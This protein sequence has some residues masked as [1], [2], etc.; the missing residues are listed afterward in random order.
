MNLERE[1]KSF[2]R[3]I[4]PGLI[5]ATSNANVNLAQVL[6]EVKA[7]PHTRE[8]LKESLAE[9]LVTRDYTTAL[10][11]T[12][13]TLESGMFSEI[14]KRLEYKI[15]PKAVE[16]LDILSFLRRIFD[17]HSDESWLEEIDRER[18]GE[19]L[20]LILPSHERLVEKLAPQ[21]FMSLEILS[22]RLAGLGYEP[23]VTHR[24]RPRREFQHAFMDVARHV[25][26]LLEK[27]ES[28]IPDLRE[29]LS[30]CHQAVLWIR[31]RRGAEG[32]SLALTY[33]MI[34]I[35]E[36]IRRLELLVQLIESILGEWKVEPAR[37]LFFEV[38]LAEIRR[39]DLRRF[40]SSNIELLAFQITEHTGKAGEHYITRTRAEWHQMLRSASLGGAIVA[41]IAI[42]KIIAGHLPWPPAPE[43]FV[44]GLI[45][46]VGFVFLHQMGGTLA[47]KQ[48]AMTAS[49]L[50]TALDEST[51]SQTHSTMEGL[52]EVIVRTI[53]SQ[54]AA[55][56]G[57]FVVAFPVAVLIAMPFTLSGYSFMSV[58]K[59]QKIMESLHPF[60][61]L[62]FW[63]AGLTGIC[64]FVSGLMAGVADNW[65]I[66]NHVGLRL[67]Q[68]E[69]LK[70]VV[71]THNLDRAIKHIDRHLGFWVGNISL[72]FFLGMLPALGTITGLPLNIRHITFSSAQF[73]AA[74]MT[75]KFHVP[76]VTSLTVAASV[77]VIGLINL[78]VSF[79][80]T[81]YVVIRS[82]R[83]RFS[84]TP[85][86]LRKLSKRLRYHPAE[87]I[88]PTKDPA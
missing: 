79:S 59:A 43:A 55:V 24:L 17:S 66:F 49:T 5:G 73:G 31:S 72:G 27:G 2:V 86:L 30:R 1:L 80:L 51:A 82:R 7:S 33:R 29:A 13:L 40:F 32:V 85:L 26:L 54:L 60:K 42:A 28:A 12:G 14:Y 64:L 8:Q 77:F 11:E 20:D 41:F 9:F 38:V 84:A 21:L 78:T 70:R 15:L 68:A 37:Q 88:L 39:F 58:E 69:I 71:G 56:M 63:Y 48:P 23:I 4:R 6:D 34:K 67:R 3:Q 36:V 47:T 62:S 18:F 57:N 65:F 35:Q 19:L 45:Y 76:L 10:T 61:S 81:L 83:I 74:L 50:A 75:L 22:L 52:S 44:Y 53:R 16:S 25:H 46:A 87:F